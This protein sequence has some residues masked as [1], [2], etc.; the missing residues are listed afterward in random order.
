MAAPSSLHNR[1]RLRRPG[2]FHTGFNILSLGTYDLTLNLID[3]WKGSIPWSDVH[4]LGN[5]RAGQA[6]IKGKFEVIKVP[7]QGK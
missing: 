6:F 7:A 5:A 4:W 3:Y 2:A 1:R